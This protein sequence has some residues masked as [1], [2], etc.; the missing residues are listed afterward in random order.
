ML[1]NDVGNVVLE[2]AVWY[3]KESGDE[4]SWKGDFVTFL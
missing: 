4:I 1:K 2:K 3:Y